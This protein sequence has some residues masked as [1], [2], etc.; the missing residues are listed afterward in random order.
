MGLLSCFEVARTD[1]VSARAGGKKS[2]DSCEAGIGDSIAGAWVEAAYV[3]TLGYR[4]RW[5]DRARRRLEVVRLLE[6]TLYFCGGNFCRVPSAALAAFSA[7]A[8]VAALVPPELPGCMEAN[9][10]C[11]YLD[12]LM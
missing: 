12:V 4:A 8:V 1:H 7:G 11:L 3:G 6:S 5:Q 9:S 10:D 2:S